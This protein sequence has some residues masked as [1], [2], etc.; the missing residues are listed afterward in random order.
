MRFKVN[1]EHEHDLEYLDSR[2]EDEIKQYLF[3]SFMDLLESDHVCR[4]KDIK[5][6]VAGA[7]PII[8]YTYVVIYEYCTHPEL[9]EELLKTITGFGNA[10]GWMDWPD[11]IMA[12]YLDQPKL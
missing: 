5:P 3:E 10:A 11:Y 1:L 8:I 6:T 2:Q 12:K 7:G 4:L 9:A